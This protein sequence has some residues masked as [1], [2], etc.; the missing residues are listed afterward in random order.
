MIVVVMMIVM[1]MMMIMLKTM[2]II[3]MIIMIIMM[4]VD[5]FW[6]LLLE[7]L[8]DDNTAGSTMEEVPLWSPRME[9]YVAWV[10]SRVRVHLGVQGEPLGNMIGTHR[11]AK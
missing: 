10:G 11:I 4:R 1:I 3:M 6:E 8:S 7:V 2:I 9:E 5:R